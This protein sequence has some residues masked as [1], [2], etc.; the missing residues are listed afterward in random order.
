MVNKEGTYIK[1]I[2]SPF[3]ILQFG[4]YMCTPDCRVGGT[5]PSG[6]T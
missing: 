6:V 3:I 5:R 1:E 4:Y 2:I